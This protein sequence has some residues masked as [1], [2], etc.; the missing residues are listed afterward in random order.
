MLTNSKEL[1]I[2]AKEKKYC[3]P[4]LNINNL[5]WTRFILEECENLKS[6]VIIGVSEGAAKYMGGFKTVSDMVRNLYDYLNI[7]IPVVLHLDH[8][9]TFESCKEAIDAGFTSVMIDASHLPLN[10]NIETTKQVVDYARGNN[11]TVEA[12]VGC[13]AGEEDGIKNDEMYTNV[14]DAKVFCLETNIDSFAPAV[15]NAHGLYKGEPKLDFNRIKEIREVTNLPLVMHGGSGI[16][17]H[18][19]KEAID[20]GICKLNINT[21]LQVAWTK[22]LRVFLNKDNE[23]YDPRKVIKS[24]EQAIKETVKEKCELL[25]SVERA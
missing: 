1:L 25:G 16:P 12:E 22:D 9:T 4:H 10:E 5:E 13:L 2:D 19:L 7:T 21:E 14:E 23:T 11:V 8:G 3:V 18:Q 17:E 15:G 20:C 24:G 6:P